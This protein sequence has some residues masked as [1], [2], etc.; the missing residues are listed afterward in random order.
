MLVQEF[1]ENSAD[2]LPNKPA[3]ICGKKRITYADINAAANQMARALRDAGVAYGD[4]VAILMDNSIEAVIAIWAILKAD[5]VFLVIN[6][7]TK[8]RKILYILDN[9]RVSALMVQDTKWQQSKISTD[10]APSL[11]AVIVSGENRQ[12]ADDE[13]PLIASWQD[14]KEKQSTD[15]LPTQAIDIDLAALIYT[16]GTTGN[17]K[18]VMLTHHNIVSASTSITEYLENVEDD[19]VLSVLPLSFDYGLYQILMAAQFGG[20]VVLERNYLFPQ[21]I[22]DTLKREHVTGFPIVPTIMSILLKMNELNDDG[23]ASLRYISSTAAAL[24]ANHIVAFQERFPNVAIYSMYGLTECKR[25]S[26]LPP[27]Q[28]RLR[29]DS[30]GRGMPNEQ[31]YL[32][33]ENGEEIK[34]H[35]VIGELV[36]RGANV[37][38]GYWEMPEETARI[39]KPGK[40]PGEQVLYSGDL[41]KRDEEGYLYFVSR[42]DDIIKSRGEKVSPREVESVLYEL[43]DVTEAAV[44]GV[45]DELLGQAI[46]AFVALVEG[47]KL[48]EKELL[49]HC[50]K[51]LE[52]FMIPK[53]VEIRAS[54]PRTSSGK[55]EKKGL[56]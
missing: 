19:I 54:L 55:I 33:D 40:F 49:A 21:A 23:L 36:I 56:K 29:P 35:G 15:Q 10:E 47:S 2:R 17:P 22:I 27:D 50:A 25:V 30:V 6:P 53:L 39:L 46:K 3:I 24:P 14:V 12:T 38:R 26:Y 8:K 5:A 52:S 11:K 13:N 31:V 51:H 34:E 9:C 7:T 42:K 16:S 43:E 32:V 4:R 18:G 44:I 28:I 1:L 48:T 45:A 20:T 41:F 37:S